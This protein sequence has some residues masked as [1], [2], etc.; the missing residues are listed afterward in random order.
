GSCN[1]SGQCQLLQ[2]FLLAALPDVEVSCRQGRRG[3]FEVA[4]DGHLVHSK[5][6]SLAFPQPGSV[7][8]QVRRA[9]SGEQM[10]TAKE[11]PIK[12]CILM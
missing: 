12:D 4:V 2:Q 8:E 9:Q 6:S 7:L 10:E 1:F 3:S 5:L 11:E